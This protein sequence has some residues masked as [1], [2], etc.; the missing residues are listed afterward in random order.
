MK[1]QILISSIF[2]FL[3]SICYCQK[4]SNQIELNT[5]IRFENYPK[6]SYNYAGRAS[7]DFL[8]MKGK[9]SGI[10]LGFNYC[11]NKDIFLKFGLGYFKQSF[12]TIENTNSIFGRTVSNRPINY[13]SPLLISYSTDAYHYNNMNINLGIEKQFNIAKNLEL[14]TG[15][16][17][18]GYYNLSQYYHLTMNPFDNN[19]D[20]NKKEKRFSGFLSN[21]SLGFY[22]RFGRYS[23]GPSLVLPIYDSWKKDPIFL[24]ENYDGGKNK[25]FNGIGIGITAKISL[26]QKMKK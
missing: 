16:N 24:E 1:K 5:F 23:I 18:G 4:N 14:T 9:N 22:K 25:W 8:K 26:Q 11:L 15:I 10:N 21:I 6:F 12:N 7:S 20:F 3:V 17:L 19:L 2:L 13:V